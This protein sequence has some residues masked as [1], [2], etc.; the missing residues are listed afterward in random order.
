MFKNTR[1]VNHSATDRG[2]RTRD[3][4]LETALALFRERGFDE[5][6]M[7]DVAAAA[8]MAPGAAY[9]Y[10]PSKQHLVLAYYERVQEEFAARLA[11]TLGDERSLARRIELAM[12]LKLDTVG[13]DRRLLQAVFR[14]ALDAASPLSVF[15]GETTAERERSIA[16]FALV[17][18]RQKLP[19]DLAAVAPRMLW[20]AHL[21]VLF[22][23]LKDTSPAAAAARA[24]IAPFA[25]TLSLLLRALSMPGLGALRRRSVDL[26]TRIGALLEQ[27]S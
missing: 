17:L 20:L 5:T 19:A 25:Q 23:F 14:H 13:T 8:Q 7:R 16:A 26:S 15:G 2:D 12:Q 21:L 6:S 11:D 22:L 27:T 24:L 10:F 9:Y 1:R 18:S 3:H 4:V